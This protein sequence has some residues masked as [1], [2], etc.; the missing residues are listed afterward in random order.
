MSLASVEVAKY[1]RQLWDGHKD[2]NDEF[3]DYALVIQKKKWLRDE[4]ATKVD[5]LCVSLLIT[6]ATSVRAEQQPNTLTDAEQAAGWHLLFDGTSTDGWRN[7]KSQ[8]IGKGW[9]VADGELVRAR[10]SR[11]HL[12]R[13][14]I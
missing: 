12:D 11:R 8:T 10:R 3:Q 7:Y 6:T 13:R 14:P 1:D 4:L 5:W 9:Q 2:A